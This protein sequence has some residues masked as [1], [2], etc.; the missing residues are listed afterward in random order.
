MNWKPRAWRDAERRAPVPAALVVVSE[1]GYVA[2]LAWQHRVTA[3][4]VL[5]ADSAE[6]QVLPRSPGKQRTTSNWTSTRTT[7]STCQTTPTTPERSAAARL[8]S[9]QLQERR[10]SQLGRG[11]RRAYPFRQARQL[12]SR[13]LDDE[14]NARKVRWAPYGVELR[15]G[16]RRIPGFF[17]W[18]QQALCNFGAPEK[19]ARCRQI[20]RLRRRLSV[21]AFFVLV[22]GKQCLQ[23]CVMRSLASSIRNRQRGHWFE[24]RNRIRLSRF[25]LTRGQRI[26]LN[27]IN[28]DIE[29]KGGGRCVLDTYT[30]PHRRLWRRVIL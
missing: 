1:P 10:R 6:Y 2:F 12:S 26:S 19:S 4:P 14:A 18:E 24:D 7:T 17:D 11:L 13:A 21:G 9:P 3:N 20:Q 25:H 15:G 27:P 23:A 30:V 29:V 8:R 22:D 5:P 28:P 16:P